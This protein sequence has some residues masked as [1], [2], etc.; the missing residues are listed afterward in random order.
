LIWITVCLVA[1]GASA[2]TLFSGFGLGTLLLPAF[3]LVFPPE[4]AVA[5]TALVHLTNNLFKLVLVGRLARLRAVLAFGI[6]A[7]LGALGGAWALRALSGLPDLGSY[8]FLGH[9][10]ELTSLKL[11]IGLLIVAFAWVELRPGGGSGAARKLGLGWG[12]VISGFF[13]G[14]S[15]HQGALRSAFLVG[16][17]LSKE[18]FIATGIW[19]AVLVDVSRL[20]VYGFAF[21]GPLIE[22]SRE[23][24][25]WRLLL[26]ATFSAFAGAWIGVRL[27]KKVTLEG[28][29]RLVGVLLIL[30]GLGMALGWV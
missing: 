22:G 3:A 9:R 19:C 15:G 17:G 18:R 7:L 11:A 4:I 1:L 23:G 21:I 5:A 6:P 25:G 13:G 14:L 20:S 16:S 28:V 2:L 27:V 29:R 8:R 26:A 10:F 24:P 30:V 12:G